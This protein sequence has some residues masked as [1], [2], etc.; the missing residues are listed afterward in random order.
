MNVY[1][2]REGFISIVVICINKNKV[3]LTL[4]QISSKDVNGVIWLGAPSTNTCLDNVTHW[5]INSV[6]IVDNL[7]FAGNSA[8]IAT[9]GSL[10]VLMGTIVFALLS[11]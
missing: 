5:T 6:Y 10:G 3:N 1:P 11:P 4:L 7:I 2:V 8:A 9:K